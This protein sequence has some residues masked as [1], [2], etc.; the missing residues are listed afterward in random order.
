MDAVTFDDVH[1][2][3]TGEEWNLLDPFQKNLYNDVMLETYMN[4]KAI[5]YN[6]E[7][8][9]LEEH[10]QSSRRQ[11]RYTLCHNGSKPCEHRDIERSNIK[12][13]F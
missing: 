6:W 13:L 11:E 5:G 3:F 7:D 9:H 10:C 12:C 4:L 2:N 8:H 1:V